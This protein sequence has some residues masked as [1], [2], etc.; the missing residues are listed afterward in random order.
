[1]KKTF[2][3]ALKGFKLLNNYSRSIYI[4]GICLML[5]LVFLDIYLMCNLFSQN[6]FEYVIFLMGLF[7]TSVLVCIITV[8][9]H[10]SSPLFEKTILLILC[11]A[12]YICFAFPFNRFLSQTMNIKNSSLIGIAIF[13][14]LYKIMEIGNR[15]WA[16][17][18][19]IK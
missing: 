4:I 15:K 16:G 5:V 13:I 17:S 7:L 2:I 11:I 1:M 19:V 3:Q 6:G 10:P 9:L 14:L 12:F 18:Q 8:L